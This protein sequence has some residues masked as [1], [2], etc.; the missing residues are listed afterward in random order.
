M[1]YY[2]AV[3][4]SGVGLLSIGMRYR[5]ST[6]RKCLIDI[7]M[8]EELMMRKNRG[9]DISYIRVTPKRL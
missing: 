6:S 8:V 9:V 4:N 5:F 2:T 3:F 1:K 7:D